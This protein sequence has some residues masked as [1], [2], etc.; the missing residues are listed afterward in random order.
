MRS[1]RFIHCNYFAPYD[2]RLLTPLTCHNGSL[3]SEAS[4]AGPPEL[5]GHANKQTSLV[6]CLSATSFPFRGKA[7][8]G[9]IMGLH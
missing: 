9:V 7:W 5:E 1:F 3:R 2:F 6:A 8:A 4:K